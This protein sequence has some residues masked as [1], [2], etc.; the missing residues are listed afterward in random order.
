MRLTFQ[1]WLKITGLFAWLLLI[2]SATAVHELD[3]C[4]AQAVNTHLAHA[5]VHCIDS[6]S[7]PQ[8]YQCESGSC[9]GG[10]G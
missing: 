10:P 8:G 6:T 2:A 1:K 4:S 5:S 3:A 7:C 9:S